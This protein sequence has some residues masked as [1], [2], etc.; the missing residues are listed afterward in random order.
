MPITFRGTCTMSCGCHGYLTNGR[1]VG[2]VTG[3]CCRVNWLH[4]GCLGS[5]LERGVDGETETTEDFTVINIHVYYI[6]LIIQWPDCVCHMIYMWMLHDMHV[7]QCTCNI[8]SI[9]VYVPVY[10]YICTCRVCMCVPYH[11]GLC[12][13][14]SLPSSLPSL[15]PSLH[16]SQPLP[17]LPPPPSSEPLSH[18]QEGEGKG[19]RR[20]TGEREGGNEREERSGQVYIIYCIC[21]CR[22]MYIH[23]PHTYMYVQCI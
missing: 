7:T 17:A 15:L 1:V 22:Y 16:C 23:N 21:T 19:G 14:S 18:L 12:F 4:L 2:K 3:L 5:I 6:W 11:T 8:C 13:L 9:D 20:N 10:M